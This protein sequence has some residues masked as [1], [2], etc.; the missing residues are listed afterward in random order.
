M[1]KLRNFYYYL[2]KICVIFYSTFMT[3]IIALYNLNDKWSVRELSTG[4]SF[5]LFHLPNL[6]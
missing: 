3:K 4:F 2:L 1:I 5:S 6:G